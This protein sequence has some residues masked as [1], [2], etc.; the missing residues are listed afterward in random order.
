[1]FLVSVNIVS[2]RI[3]NLVVKSQRA[4]KWSRRIKRAVISLLVFSVLVWANNSSLLS[5]SPTGKAEL[6]AHRGLHQTFEIKG[7]KWNSNT[8]AIIH[9]PEHSYI[10]NTIPSMEAAFAAG[11]DMV[12]FDVRL[13]KDRKLA[14]FHDYSLEHRTDGRGLIEDATMEELR[15]LDVGY[16]Y[17]AD[18]G[19]TYPLR[20][21]G[22]GLMVSIE[23][24]LKKFPNKRFLIHVKSGG[25]ESGRIL[26][27]LFRSKSPEWL[28]GVGVYG[29]QDANDVINAVFPSVKT[30]SYR[31]LKKA[32]ISY[33]LL[34]WTGYIPEAMRETQFQIHLKYASYIWGWPDKFLNRMSKV[35]TRVILVNGDGGWSEGFDSE[36]ELKLIPKGFNGL[37]WSNKADRVA[38]SEMFQ[39]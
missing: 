35:N 2:N 37:I 39:P 10:E 1:M 17:T 14:V 26:V 29:G 13:T 3:V 20:G 24:V 22:V 16:G 8:A 28:E 19:E 4:T 15:K 11:A 30:H 27:E 18:G 33:E 9:P 38:K 23:E 36:D 34:G 32:F 6:L 25:E 7:L 31:S 5:S 12:E 21:K